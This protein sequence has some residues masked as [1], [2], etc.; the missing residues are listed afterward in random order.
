MSTIKKLCVAIALSSS[1]YA[2]Q[3]A[4][5]DGVVSNFPEPPAYLRDVTN[6][7]TTGSGDGTG[8]FTRNYIPAL[9]T[10]NDGRVGISMAKTP[11][12]DGYDYVRLFLLSP[13]K[14]EAALDTVTTPQNLSPAAVPPVFSEKQ[15]LGGTDTNVFYFNGVSTTGNVSPQAWQVPGEININQFMITSTGAAENFAICESQTNPTS[16]SGNDVYVLNFITATKSSGTLTLK[17]RPVTVT[18]A[19][20]KTASAYISAV[21]F[22]SAVASSAFVGN[23]FSEPVFTRDGKLLVYRT[24]CNAFSTSNCTGT[25]SDSAPYIDMVYI[26]L[27]AAC[28]FTNLGSTILPKPVAAAYYD[29]NMNPSQV[30]IG[31]AVYGFAEYPLKDPMGNIY[32]AMENVPGIYPWIDMD[33][34]NLFFTT[35]K[36]TLYGGFGEGYS[37]AKGRFDSDVLSANCGSSPVPAACADPVEEVTLTRGI[38]FA[39]LWSKGK[40]VLLDGVLNNTDYGMDATLNEAR[41]VTLYSSGSPVRIGTGR[42]S[43]SDGDM[44][45]GTYGYH[46][47]GSLIN[48]SF[49]GSQENLWN[50]YQKLQPVTPRDVVWRINSGT[51]SDEV[52][53]DDYLNHSAL[54]VSS[55]VGLLEKIPSIDGAQSAYNYYDGFKATLGSN[56][57]LAPEAHNWTNLQLDATSDFLRVQN[58]ATSTNHGDLPP[59]GAVTDTSDTTRIEPVAIGGI[60]GKGLWLSGST[61]ITYDMNDV[62]SQNLDAWYVGLFFDNRNGAYSKTLLSFADGSTI[63]VSSTQITFD[64]SSGSAVSTALSSLSSGWHHYG[65]QLKTDGS[66]LLVTFYLDGY[67]IDNTKVFSVSDFSVTGGNLVVGGDAKGWL[68]DFK[69]FAEEVNPEV[70]CNHANGTLMR[71]DEAEN[72]NWED[73]ANVYPSASHEAIE[74]LLGDEADTIYACYHDYSADYAAHLGNIPAA[75]QSVRAGL[76]MPEAPLYYDMDRPDSSENSFCQSCHQ[77]VQKD[78]PLSLRALVNLPE[79]YPFAKSDPRRQPMQ[80]PQLVYGVYPTGWLGKNPIP[81]NPSYIDEWILSAFVDGDHDGDGTLN[82][83][84]DDDDNDGIDDFDEFSEIEDTCALKRNASSQT[85][86]DGDDKGNACDSDDD[87]DGLLDILELAFGAN[88]LDTDSDDDTE[89][90]GADNCT[91]V[92]NE[93]QLDQDEDGFGNA[94]DGDVN[95]D[96]RV[97]IADLRELIADG[98]GVWVNNLFGYTGATAVPHIN[99]AVS[100]IDQR[101]LYHWSVEG[102]AYEPGPSGLDCAGN[103][104]CPE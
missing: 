19:S 101:E 92:L 27:S 31:D 17:K 48:S 77:G 57:V 22:G 18:V 102:T 63:S 84:D 76:L 24:T 90:D 42:D 103:I 36:S 87:N 98:L 7:N 71:I 2:V 64:P 58:A 83:T 33:G 23:S 61:Q 28:D 38:A 44:S 14:L 50:Y 69:V 40:T 56:Y 21:T 68:D 70:A 10:S 80:P 12:I 53:F 95:N 41:N 5:P 29:S 73:L 94:C 20:P 96:N 3:A 16:S 13:E 67:A 35:I 81:T 4:I 52:A 34:D 82:G 8:A 32:S 74:T 65:F 97:N 66:D 49:I 39:G 75:H 104:P 45:S 47:K 100:E 93:Q 54:I 79:L 37:Y 62:A 1:G 55:M 91:L 99:K 59:Y 11:T 88:P 51:T 46:P 26:H 86:T 89:L 15:G 25:Q 78:N 85:D 9:R 43:K 30:V 72:D 6:I 60:Y